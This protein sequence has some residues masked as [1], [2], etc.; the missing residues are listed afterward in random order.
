MYSSIS[1]KVESFISN[2][3]DMQIRACPV[4]GQ[5]ENAI[6]ALN[7]YN[8]ILVNQKIWDNRRVYHGYI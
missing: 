3:V 1:L 6:S 5:E 2:N 7:A 8:R 4:S